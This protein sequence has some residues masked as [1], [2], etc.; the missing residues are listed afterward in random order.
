[1]SKGFS[2]KQNKSKSVGLF[3]AILQPRRSLLRLVVAPSVIAGERSIRF[4]SGAE[5]SSPLGGMKGPFIPTA[6]VHRRQSDGLWS[7]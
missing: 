3:Y 5:R 2:K 4:A 1:M 6:T 7:V